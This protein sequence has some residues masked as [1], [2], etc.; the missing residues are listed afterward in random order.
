MAK[1]NKGILGGFSGNIAN[2]CGSAWKGRAVVRSAKQKQNGRATEAMQAQWNEM[3]KNAFLYKFLK[4]FQN[5]LVL[6]N[7]NSLLTFQQALYSLINKKVNYYPASSAVLDLF[8]N[9]YITDSR[10][11]VSFSQ[12]R[13]GDPLRVR[14]DEGYH[15]EPFLADVH[16]CFYKSIWSS[17]IKYF[18]FKD[19]YIPD[20][21]NVSDYDT[22]FFNGDWIYGMAVVKIGNEV[23]QL[24]FEKQDAYPGDYGYHFDFEFYL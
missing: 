9:K 20:G 12:D 21:I 22:D 7:D 3:R 19:V 15:V 1:Y 5:D 17:D 24:L 6:I 13:V 18:H 2:V 10:A 23:T 14:F 4:S 16:F 11:F 8:A